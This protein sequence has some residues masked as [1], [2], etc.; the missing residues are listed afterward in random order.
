[1]TAHDTAPIREEERFDEARVAAYLRD[2]VPELVGDADITFDQFPGGAANLTY[3]AVA[4]DAELVLRRAPLGEVAKGGHDMAREHRV[5][6]RLWDVFPEAPRA[7]HYCADSDVMGKPF[8]VME[9]RHGHVVRTEWPASFGGDA[10]RRRVCEELVDT[11]GALH[12]VEPAAVALDDLGRPDGFVDRQVAGWARR[13][14]AAMTREV[15]EMETLTRRLAASV[16]EPEATTILHNDYKLDN[17]MVSDRGE[18]V[19]VF[20]WDMATRGDPLVDFGTLLAYWVDREGPSH[21]V[22]GNRVQPLTPYMAKTEVIDRYVAVTGFDVTHIRY[23]LALAY[24]RI[25]VILEQIYTRYARGQTSDERFAQFGSAAPLLADT[26][27]GVLEGGTL[28]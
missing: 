10:P 16:P 18:I 26:A 9:R 17:T 14:E 5:L 20:D 2:H 8:F 22:F 23:F 15:P 12:R 25:A 19:A 27:R 3:R 28:V 11:L 4:G 21:T 6:S 24:Y 1:M 7:Y 13:W